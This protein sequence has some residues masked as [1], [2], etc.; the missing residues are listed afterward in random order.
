MGKFR[1]F[2]LC[3]IVFIVFYMY[4]GSIVIFDEVIEF[5]VCGG[6]LVESF[7]FY[8]SLFIKSFMIFEDEKVVL[9]VFLCSLI[10]E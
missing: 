6:N 5:Y 10:D 9:V 7:N 4:D 1:V 8:C 2:I 3:N